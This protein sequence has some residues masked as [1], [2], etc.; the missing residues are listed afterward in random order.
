MRS[1]FLLRH[2]VRGGT[3]ALLLGGSGVAFAQSGQ[4]PIGPPVTDPVTNKNRTAP[5]ELP[6]QRPLGA[7]LPPVPETATDPAPPGTRG[8]RVDGA[9]NG[10]NPAAGRAPGQNPAQAGGTAGRR[11]SNIQVAE[12]VVTRLDRAGKN[13]NGE[14]IRF[15]FDP[16][17]DWHSYTNQGAQGVASKDAEPARDAKPARSADGNGEATSKVEADAKAALAGVEAANK[18]TTVDTPKGDP[19][20]DP[21][22]I[23]E[24][25]VTSRTYV[26]THARAEDGTDMYGAATSASPVVT[27]PRTAPGG[28]TSS[29]RVDQPLPTNFTN[30]KEGSFV[31][32]RY[33]KL[34]DVN[35]VLN[36]T[37]IEMPLNPDAAGG[38]TGRATGAGT[39]GAPG[40]AGTGATGT[41]TTGSG[42]IGTGGVGPTAPAGA[43]TLPPAVPTTPTGPAIPR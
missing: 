15:A 32:V 25:A 35:E 36:L 21:A 16:T 31:S 9:Q 28:V 2:A 23:L 24:M 26:Y 12:G 19:Q 17:Q 5:G 30:I 18:A 22:Q 42:T 6:A 38:G 11:A 1:P 33:R 3:L 37:L 40:T 20:A 39:A 43:G 10:A 41:G 29:G 14:L 34:G 27:S 13:I 4:P 7:E 8:V